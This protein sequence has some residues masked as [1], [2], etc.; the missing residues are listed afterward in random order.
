MVVQ[1]KQNREFW[2]A[3]ALNTVPDLLIAG[4]PA[5]VFEDGLLLFFVIF[6]GLQAL[7]FKL[8]VKNAIW[9]WFLYLVRDK[10]RITQRLLDFLM[11][12]QFPEPGACVDS[13]ES[14]LDEVAADE[15]I[16][17]KTRL[18][19][20]AE[21]GAILYI[22]NSFRFQEYFRLSMPYDEAIEEYSR[23]VGHT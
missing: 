3:A 8:W 4:V 23:K 16:D 22:R 19:A 14:Y 17:L 2:F 11:T 10:R 21:L 1:R 15:T 13:T 7:Y 12:N 9:L 6:F 5:L 20:A 18:L